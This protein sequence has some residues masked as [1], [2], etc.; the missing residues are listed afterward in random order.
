MRRLGMIDRVCLRVQSRVHG[1]QIHIHT[2]TRKV[3]APIDKPLKDRDD[4]NHGKR[5]DGII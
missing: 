1:I 5:S 3:L 4:K 2:R